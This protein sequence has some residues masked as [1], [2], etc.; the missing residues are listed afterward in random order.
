MPCIPE[1]LDPECYTDWETEDLSAR[2]YTL[3]RDMCDAE[4]TSSQ[5]AGLGFWCCVFGVR[6]RVLRVGFVG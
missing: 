6:V 1:I 5:E 3:G 2:L 4:A